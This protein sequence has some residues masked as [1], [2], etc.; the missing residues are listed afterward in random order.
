MNKK[1]LI[2]VVGPTAIGKTKL[3][4]A[5]AQHFKTEI[6]SADS[7]QFF[8][9][10]SIGTAVPSTA[11]LQAVPHHFIQHLSIYT[12]YSVG[13]F[14]KAALSDIKKLHVH[15]NFVVLVGGSGLYVDAVV[16]GLNQFPDIPANIR[17]KL[18]ERLNKEGIAHLQIEL[19]ERDPDY[20]A[21]VDLSNPHR[22]IRAL[23][24]CIATGRP[25][26]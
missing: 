24:V 23:E 26:S 22:V 3:A 25:F 17:Q 8:K 20:Y 6:L 21:S 9:E 11:E 2:A 10:M 16:H 4:I 7:R 5:L 18:S 14:E 15:N 1:T 12:P 13:D 19:K